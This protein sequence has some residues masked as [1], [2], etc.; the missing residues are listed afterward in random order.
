MA[1]C[2]QTSSNHVP[3]F[4]NPREESGVCPAAMC[5]SEVSARS[6]TKRNRSL[7]GHNESTDP[8]FVFAQVISSVIGKIIIINCNDEI[9]MML[10]WVVPVT[11]KL[12]WMSQTFLQGRQ[13][14]VLNPSLEIHVG[15]TA[16]CN[17]AP[18]LSQVDDHVD[19]HGDD[20]RFCRFKRIC[21]ASRTP[22]SA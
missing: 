19:D 1:W 18:P 15:T 9:L 10:W 8:K 13:Q 16:H 7:A 14:P 12:T 11:S 3:R 20:F 4:P 22:L 17:Q 21:P 5:V 6:D 2:H